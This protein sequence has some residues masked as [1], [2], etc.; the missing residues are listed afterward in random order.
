MALVSQ[1]YPPDTAHGGIG[2]QTYLK[3][4]GL[5]SLG[6]QV[7]VL[8]CSVDEHRHIYRDGEVR[9]TR[10]PGWKQKF[11]VHTDA[12]RWLTYSVEVAAELA[13]LHRT[14]SLDIIDFPDWGSE[15]YIHL[16][17]RSEGNRAPAVVIHLH[18]P[19]VMF[20]HKLGWPKLDSEFYRAGTCMEKT[21]LRLA[22]AVFSSSR[23]SA[24]CCADYYG[25]DAEKVPVLHTGVD[26]ELF[27]PGLKSKRT[28]PTIVFVGKLAES[29]GIN[30]LVDAACSILPR[31]PNLQL[32]LVGPSDQSTRE[33]LRDR[34]EAA[35]APDL[36]AL[37]GFLDRMELPSHL[38]R[39]HVFAAPSRYEGGPGFVYLEAMA[40]GLPVI[41]TT[42]SGATEVVRH[43]K[44][45]LLIPPDDTEALAAALSRLLSNPE[46]SAR[47]G[48]QAR[49][50]VEAE[51]DSR[52]CLRELE[53]FYLSVIDRTA[54]S[55]GEAAIR[56]NGRR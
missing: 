11:P 13:E 29:K 26:L 43:E 36:L 1:E 21:C 34:A 46:Q 51:A 2:T 10:I 7:Y 49:L 35:G 38:C 42:G 4:H 41:G 33:R 23:C 9:V 44:T 31:F 5:A 27:Q 16:L 56:K 17:N 53:Q 15:G 25:L 30:T 39:A 8:S 6:H 22:D 14:E 54:A 50:Y 45:G 40:C 37:M 32:S 55:G 3:A 19:L 47:L 20:A 28:R 48:K 52:K 12:V 24:E 18:G